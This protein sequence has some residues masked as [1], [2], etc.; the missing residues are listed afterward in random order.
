MPCFTGEIQNNQI[1]FMCGVRATSVEGDA[2]FLPC[3]ALVDTGA[4]GT[5]ISKSIAENAGL[6]DSGW[7]HIRGV[8]GTVRCPTYM[9]DL[10]INIEKMQHG[11]DIND[12]N[13]ST[14]S[15]I[16]PIEVPAIE[17]LGHDVLIGMDIIASCNLQIHSHGKFTFCL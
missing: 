13:A 4:Q 2:N 12:V 3:K 16:F 9:I 8:S 17:N 5:C 14:Y 6:E 10:R 7:T 15:K 11:R 1:M